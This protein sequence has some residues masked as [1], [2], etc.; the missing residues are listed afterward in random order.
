MSEAESSMDRLWR[1]QGKLEKRLGQD[2][3]KKPK[4]MHWQTYER[5]ADHIDDIE[6]EKDAL[7]VLYMLRAC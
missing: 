1:K 6:Q 3:E 2:Y 7:F 5:L 4:G